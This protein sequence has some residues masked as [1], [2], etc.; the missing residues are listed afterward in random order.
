MGPD[1]STQVGGTAWYLMADQP[2]EVIAGAWDWMTFM[3]QPEVQ[4]RWNTEGSFS[5]WVTAAVE[6]PSLQ[7]MWTT[8]RLGSWLQVAYE[9]VADID[10]T[11]PGPLIGPYTETRDAIRDSLDRLI[12]EGQAPAETLAEADAEVTE[13][14]ERYNDENF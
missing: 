5:P 14:V 3:N 11:W 9:Q 13:A 8:T 4:A 12:L 2:D 1:Q 7:E 10:A 6:D